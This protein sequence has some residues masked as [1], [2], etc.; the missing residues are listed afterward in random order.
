[1]SEQEP[2]LD[3]SRSLGKSR[4]GWGSVRRGNGQ[5]S[6]FFKAAYFRTEIR[7]QRRE[8]R[9]PPPGDMLGAGS[10]EQHSYKYNAAESSLKHD[11][12]ADT[13]ACMHMN[14]A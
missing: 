2:S 12:T 11:F 3:Q 5:T 6:T 8:R 7:T 4:L 9:E 10:W 1:M 14:P 13:Q